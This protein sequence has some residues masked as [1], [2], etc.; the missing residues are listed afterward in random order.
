MQ[1]KRKR[2]FRKKIKLPLHRTPAQRF[3]MELRRREKTRAKSRE[4]IARIKMQYKTKA[5]KQ[6][7]RQKEK[8]AGRVDRMLSVVA[9]LL[10]AGIMVLDGLLE[11][12][13]RYPE[14]AQKEAGS[15]STEN[16][17]QK[18]GVQYTSNRAQKSEYEYNGF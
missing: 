15:C 16:K 18:Y 5:V 4:K 6:K 11:S 2:S 7:G 3:R 13:Q 9:F 17:V 12:R 8:A 14:K 10:G 1:K